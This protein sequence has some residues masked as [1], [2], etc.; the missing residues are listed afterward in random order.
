MDHLH[1]ATSPA[2][3]IDD[4][5]LEQVARESETDHRSVLRRIAGLPVKGRAG[6]RIDRVL[7]ARNIPTLGRLA[8]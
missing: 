8:A 7:A 2:L 3:A 5:T 6:L 4:D 1:D